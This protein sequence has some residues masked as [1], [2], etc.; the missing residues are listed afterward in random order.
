[1]E[2]SSTHSSAASP[3][4][5]GQRLYPASPLSWLAPLWA[6][7]CGAAASG[8]WKWSG[9]AL[10]RLLLG[11]LLAGPLLGLVWDAVLAL[12]SGRVL[13]LMWAL[14]LSAQPP[15]HAS[16]APAEYAPVDSAQ[17]LRQS[18]P[19]TLPGSASHRVAAWFLGF[20]ARW[21][22]AR[23]H[24]GQALVQLTAAT[25]FS[26]VVAM[27]L[28]KQPLMLAVAGLAVVLAMGFGPR[29][30]SICL[31]TALPA[32]LAWL[33]GHASY[34]GLTPVSAAVATSFGWAFCASH[35]VDQGLASPARQVVPQIIVAGTLVA[36]KQP[37]AAS[38]VASLASP[39]LL[40]SLLLEQDSGHECYFHALQAAV[41]ASMAVA[42]LA[43]G[44]RP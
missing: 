12:L 13:W 7:A 23:P 24:V 20:A 38:I 26:L 29:K 37:I 28:G 5:Y 34:A 42:A 40:L 30:K 1:M 3:L 32:L 33:L 10:L 27:Q 31:F 35:Q 22:H 19:Y 14:R 44:Y 9:P 2:S 16:L 43:A 39:G 21:K 15:P 6:Y 17:V 4:L 41:A 11:L 36:I 18:M 8:A 25:L